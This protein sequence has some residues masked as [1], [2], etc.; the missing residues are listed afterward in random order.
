MHGRLS[1]LFP[2]IIAGLMAALTF[3]LE[4]SVEAEAA[5]KDGSHRHDPDY[6]VENFQSDK[7]DPT[8]QPRSRLA[9]KSMTH[10]PDDDS[11]HLDAPRFAR[12]G[13]GKPPIRISA[14]KGLVSRDG[15]HVYFTG[16]V[17][18][19]RD[20]HADK[21][22]MV[23]TTSYLHLIPDKDWAET[24]KPVEIVDANTHITGVG[25][26]LDNSTQ[27]ARILSR[28]RARYDKKPTS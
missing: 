3:W 14:E 9:A 2:L 22:E 20:A 1:Y 6:I 25:L 11:T 24:D 21:S 4:R 27:T 5:K 10:Y 15:E 18:V 7:M 13:Q 19:S 26:Q 16:N 28:V 8:G 17:R 23:L 12:F